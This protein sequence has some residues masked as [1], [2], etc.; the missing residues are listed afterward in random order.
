LDP[1]FQEGILALY[2]ASADPVGRRPFRRSV[3]VS[4]YRGAL[5]DRDE[6][7]PE[8]EVAA[9]EELRMKEFCVTITNRPGEL[10][11]VAQALAR[12]GVSIKALAASASG[13]QVT[14]HVVGHDVEATRTGLENARIV[15]EEKEILLL[16]LEDKAGEIAR[17]SGLLAE[18]GVNI[19]AIYLAGRAEDLVEVV[20]VPDDIKKAKKVLGESTL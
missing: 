14:L 12:E 13:N 5:Q 15:F 16:L 9:G 7:P 2:D 8:A 1:R 20:L 18:A 17:V 10:A 4:P 11:R 19:S 3:G 6:T